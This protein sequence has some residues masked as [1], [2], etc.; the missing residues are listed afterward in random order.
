MRKI[1]TK[2]KKEKEKE[3]KRQLLRKYLLKAGISIDVPDLKKKVFIINIFI[4][5]V[6][7]LIVLAFSII[8]KKSYLDLLIFSAGFWTTFFLFSFLF[9]WGVIFFFLDFK[10]FS[11]TRQ[12]EEILPDYLQLVSSNVAAGVPL[13][14]A[15]W[16][17][18]KPGFGVLREEIEEVAKA[19]MAGESL[20]QA[21]REFASKYNSA[22]LRR[23]INLLVEGLRTGSDV[24]ELLQKIAL[25][26]QDIYI[27]KKEMAANVSSYIIFI[28]AATLVIVPF[29]LALS[30]VLLSL[31]IK[32][33]SD[34]NIHT[35]IGYFILGFKGSISMITDFKIFSI[36]LMS[37]TSIFSACIISIIKRGNII[38]GVK[39]I[40]VFIA[41]NI[42]VYFVVFFFIT[43]VLSSFI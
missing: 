41:I 32:I 21:L 9:L 37:L 29:L 28:T 2:K 39:N 25:N 8:N 3:E 7:W 20:E 34:L 27:M 30:T 5:G 13:D 23:S 31:I 16:L 43:S 4:I 42:T 38:E 33:T 12:V 10:I 19:T 24:S 1:K 14:K 11:R 40:P 17:S 15:L 35:T 18:I 36:T 22:I 6:L 26:I